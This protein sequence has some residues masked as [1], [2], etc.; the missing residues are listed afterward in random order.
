MNWLTFILAAFLAW[1]FQLGLHGLWAI[2]DAGGVAPSLL[3]IVMVFVALHAAATPAAWAGL[4]VG[5]TVDLL[6]G[7]VPVAPV[8]RA[9]AA[10]EVIGPA[11]VGY[12]LGAYAVVQLR[13]LVFRESPLTLCLMVFAA[14]V[15]VELCV[16]TLYSI[17]GLGFVPAE[18]VA[19]WSA[20]GEL[21]RRL[22]QTVYSAVVALPIGWLLVRSR[23]YWAFRKG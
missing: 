17:R 7:P 16:V 4:L 23:R 18:P 1:A 13:G 19:N 10:Q 3:L 9:T 14:G 5:L 22:L 11:A 6:P 12:L 20:F 21:G 15:V 2:P 8:G